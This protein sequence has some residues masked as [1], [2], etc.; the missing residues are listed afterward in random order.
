[1]AMPNRLLEASLVTIP[2]QADAV[3]LE[4]EHA[5]AMRDLAPLLSGDDDAAERAIR[6]G[7]MDRL[8]WVAAR[9]PRIGS[10]IQRIVRAELS[11]LLADAGST[12]HAEPTLGD[13][14]NQ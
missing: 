4:H 9:D 8:L 13:I 6:A 5:R 12:N 7:S 2:A 3:S 14:L 10:F 11:G 1:M